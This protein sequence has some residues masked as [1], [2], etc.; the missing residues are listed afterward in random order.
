MG[1]KFDYALLI[2]QAEGD[3][4]LQSWQISE[5]SI[6]EVAAMHSGF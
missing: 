5:I 1:L 6:E 4:L 2:V 3:G